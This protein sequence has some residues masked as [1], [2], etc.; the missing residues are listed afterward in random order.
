MKIIRNILL[1]AISLYI[2]TQLLP[3]FIVFGGIQT[4]L[5]GGAILWL[6]SIT[7]KPAL[8]FVAAPFYLITFGLVSI[9]THALIFFIL[10]KIIHSIQI[11]S[12]T[13]ASFSLLGVTIP[14]FSFNL[15]EAFIIVAA[16]QIMIKWI[17]LWIAKE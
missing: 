1:E 12:F 13:L 16:T 6:L 3:G 5:I 2:L 4:Y 14:K 8:N 9:I 10:T 17:I 15:L 7:L 11:M